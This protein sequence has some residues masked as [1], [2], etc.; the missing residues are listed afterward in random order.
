V[1]DDAVPEWTED[2]ITRLGA[3]REALRTHTAMPEH[4]EATVEVGVDVLRY[5]RDFLAE[6]MNEDV[7][8][9]LQDTAIRLFRLIESD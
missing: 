1:D 4:A 9:Y 3:V 6:V 7:P 5:V 8:Q 2:L